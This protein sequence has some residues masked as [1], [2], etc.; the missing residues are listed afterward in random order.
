M[1]GEG[2]KELAIPVPG[3]GRNSLYREDY[4]DQAFKL[5]LLGAIDE[6][7][8]DFFCVSVK[9]IYNWKDEHPAF[10]Q[11]TIDGKVKADA[12]VAHSLYRSATGHEL[13]AEKLMKKEDGTFEA[14]RY[15]RYIPG[16]PNAAF[17]W[18]TNRRRQNWTDTQ[19][20]EHGITSDL[21]AIIAERRSKVSE[22][23]SGN[24]A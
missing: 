22:L 5:C 15:K 2:K 4:A 20:V 6:E 10:L 14:V 11:A 23:N 3:P 18:L 9:T 17:K 7:L 16:D 13:T 8:A 24:E 1:A 19:K 21:A 12:E